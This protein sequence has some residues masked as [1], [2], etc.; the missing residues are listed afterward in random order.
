M[1]PLSELIP[2]ESQE[3]FE[4][5]YVVEVGLREFCIEVLEARYGPR[6]WRERLPADLVATMRAA[7]HAQRAVSWRDLAPQRPLAYL[8][9]PELI[10]VL[11]DDELWGAV[12]CHHFRL[13]H[14]LIEWLRQLAQARKTLHANRRPSDA[15]LQAARTAH[16]EVSKGV[17]S[18]W[19][20][21][22]LLHPATADDCWALL[23]ALEHELVEQGRRASAGEAL[24]SPAA[25][26]RVAAAWWFDHD[27]L[28]AS[29]DALASYV[30]LLADYTRLLDVGATG[31]E[32]GAWAVAHDLA[33]S[34]VHAIGELYVIRAA[35]GH[36]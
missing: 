28:G 21:W 3:L 22:R 16:Y 7:L 5:H 29:V 23:D 14:T 8:G 11:D 12:F 4:L 27:Y 19:L 36:Q 18:G 1:G 35:L 30:S 26:D 13:R 20:R 33:A 15:E 31:A 17:G 9:L 10:G 2:A 6:F 32:V 25:W 24:L 34:M